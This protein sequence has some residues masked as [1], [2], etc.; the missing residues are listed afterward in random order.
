[1]RTSTKL[2]QILSD[3]A[4]GLS[5][6]VDGWSIAIISINSPYKRENESGKSFSEAVSNAYKL[7]NRITEVK[8]CDA[9]D[10]D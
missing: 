9:Y 8:E 4:I 3:N 6:G 7:L 2:K 1:M 10:A 5:H